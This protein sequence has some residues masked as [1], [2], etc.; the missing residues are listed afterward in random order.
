VTNVTILCDR[1]PIARPLSN[2]NHAPIA[3]RRMS[4]F[5]LRRPLPFPYPCDKNKRKK[6]AGQK[7]SHEKQNL[8][9]LIRPEFLLHTDRA[10]KGIH[11]FLERRL[12]SSK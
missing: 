10:L 6:G 8:R 4:A 9:H 12:Q 3:R 11:T 2:L 7:A 1:V 5:R